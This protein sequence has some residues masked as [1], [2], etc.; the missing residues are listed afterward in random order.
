M[1]KLIYI[2]IG[3]ALFCSCEPEYI[4]E[5][6]TLEYTV[7]DKEF[8]T[9]LDPATELFFGI[10]TTE[11][12][13]VLVLERHGNVKTVEVSRNDY[14]SHSIGSKYHNS[15]YVKVKNPKYKKKNNK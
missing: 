9:Q 12:V 2:L 3:V 4:T 14:Y 10:K 15:E 1:K 5:I 11:Q 13:Y 8:S 7:V 6:R